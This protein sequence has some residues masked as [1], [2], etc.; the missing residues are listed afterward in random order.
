MSAPLVN[1]PELPNFS[2]K[3][4]CAGC[5]K[6][7]KN[8]ASYNKHI[9][10]CIKTDDSKIEP[11]ENQQPLEENDKELKKLRE[12]LENLV[13]SNPMLDL[14]KTVN[15]NVFEQIHDMTKEELKARI[16]QAKREFNGKLDMKI[17]DA[18]LT[19]VNLVVGNMLGCVEELQEEVDKDIV[20]REATRDMLSMGFLSKIPPQIK[21]S[22]LFAVDL[23]LAIQKRRA[24]T[25]N[26]EILEEKEKPANN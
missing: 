3:S 10:N 23:G 26:V 22:G 19:V 17:S 9:S 7:Y 8:K 2:K 6:C 4:E 24:K 18:G 15:T 16:F 5:G 25:P 11:V 14:S 12:E 13:M 21:V 20:L 1:L